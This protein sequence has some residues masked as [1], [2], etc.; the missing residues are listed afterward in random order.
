MSGES[1]YNIRSLAVPPSRADKKS[2][3][4]TNEKPNPLTSSFPSNFRQVPDNQEVYLDADGFSSVVVEILERVEKPDPEALE[5]H[6]KDLITDDEDDAAEKTRVWWSG[7][8]VGA[9]LP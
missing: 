6:F 1:N 7:D 2:H 9:K 3:Y 5:Y 4:I 8:A